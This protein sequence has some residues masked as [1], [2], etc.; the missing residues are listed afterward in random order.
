V[1]PPRNAL[2]ELAVFVAVV[3]ALEWLLPGFDVNAIQPNPCWLPVLLLGLQYGTVSGLLAAGVAIVITVIGGFPEQD[4]GENLFAYLLRVWGQP[5]LWLAAA[6]VLGQFRMR[7]IEAKLELVRRVEKLSADRAAVAA[8][9][10]NLRSRCEALE[11]HVAG[12]QEPAALGLL[13]ALAEV[14]REAESGLPACFA[15][16]IERA[17]PGAQATLYRREGDTLRKYAATRSLAEAAP[18]ES[19]GFGDRLYHSIVIDR[20]S[21]SVLS[22]TGEQVL[23]GDGLAAVPVVSHGDGPVIGM[24]KL[25]TAAPELL[26]PATLGALEL[27]A[28]IFSGALVEAGPATAQ[29]VPAAAPL[30]EPMPS[31]RSLVR[32]LRIYAPT[33]PAEASP[34]T[35]VENARAAN[36]ERAVR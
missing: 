14:Q 20:A 27:M 22:P 1:L 25:E 29:P 13:A 11:R 16:I 8:Y 9:A 32:R 15:E 4:I 12:R 5:M 30:A 10:S 17:F 35:P 36:P 33:V 6:L 3:V 2:I 31:A 21:L 18:R 24:L 7:Q 19:I 26:G 34:E 23:N 28:T